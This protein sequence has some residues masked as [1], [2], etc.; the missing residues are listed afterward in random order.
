MSLSAQMRAP[1]CINQVYVFVFFVPCPWWVLSR[2]VEAIA[3]HTALVLGDHILAILLRVGGIGEEHALVAS[4]LFVLANAAGLF[5]SVFRQS[6]VAS[7]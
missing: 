1:Q 5:C 4:G 6:C 2:Q 7:C 3:F